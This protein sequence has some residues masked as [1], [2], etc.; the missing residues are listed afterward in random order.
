VKKVILFL[1]GVCSF[2]LSGIAQISDSVHVISLKEINI[3]ATRNLFYKED[4]KIVAADSFILAQNQFVSVGEFLQ[5]LTPIYIK[6]YGNGGASSLSL[7]GSGAGHTSVNW[8]GFPVNSMTTGEMDLSTISVSMIDKISVTSGASGALYGSG[9]FG[10]AIDLSTEPNWRQSFYLAV[11]SE[12]GSF[13][14]QNYGLKLTFGNQKIQSH[15]TFS[16]Q[17][18]LG[19]FPFQD[20]YS[21]GQPS[22][23]RKNNALKSFSFSQ[24]VFFQNQRNLAAEVG[25]WYAVK[26]KQIP[27]IMG[28]SSTNEQHQADSSFRFFIRLS[29]KYSK[30]SLQLKSAYI[31]DYL[32]YTDKSNA[33]DDFYAINST[34]QTQRIL[35]DISARFFTSN[36]FTFEMG[37]IYSQAFANV[38]N[39]DG[40]ISEWNYSL[41]AAGKYLISPFSFNLVLR[42]EF[43]EQINPKPLASFGANCEILR[44]RWFV[45]TNLANQFKLPSFNDKYWTPGGNPDLKPEQ[46]WTFDVGSIFYL[47]NQSKYNQLF[48]DVTA[49]KSEIKN[50]IQWT[51]QASFWSPVNY[52]S[53]TSQGI[54]SSMEYKSSF[55]K[56]NLLAFTSYNYTLTTN[57]E[58]NSGTYDMVGKQLRYVPIHSFRSTFRFE[59][60]MF[61]LT[62]SH[63]YTGKRYTTDDNNPLY[64]LPDYDITDLVVGAN[65]SF[66]RLSPSLQF[67]ICNVLNHDYQLIRAYPMQGRAFYLSLNCSFK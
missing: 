3:Y 18:S 33:S 46:G 40:Q 24:N 9:T 15:S 29:K 65:F 49:F 55:G 36:R 57:E 37:A 63:S 31:F 51:P 39:Y 61:T 35:S 30:I 19:N 53:V 34:I 62:I 66:K 1:I 38:K 2:Q 14:T 52:K 41:F 7:R 64:A 17:K 42:K 13:Q 6:S 22:E 32:H 16:T 12:L 44:N 28:V 45:R 59:Y 43:N 20:I 21:I 50:W 60:S 4:K 11:S 25:V 10:G 26:N 23:T 5:F 27:A 47:I 48:V 8:N 67:K 56:L 54:E 58:F